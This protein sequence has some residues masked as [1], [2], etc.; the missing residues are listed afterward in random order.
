VD[1]PDDEDY[2]DA[3]PD[4]SD[5]EISELCRAWLI[6]Q[7]D[8]RERADREPNHWAVEALIMANE[9]GIDLLWRLVR[10]LCALATPD[11][12]RAIDMIGVGPIED[13]I[14]ADGERAMDLIE[15]ATEDGSVLLEALTHVWCFSDPVRPRLD[16]LLERHGRPRTEG[17]GV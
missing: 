15:P 12:E 17:P 3:H 10:C 2:W 11:Q 13:M 7:N 14:S 4:P 8:G 6:E 1:H 9:D 16:R 5:E